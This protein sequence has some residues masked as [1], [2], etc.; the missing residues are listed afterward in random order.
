MGATPMLNQSIYAQMKKE[1]EKEKYTIAV[2][3]IS[4]ICINV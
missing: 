4:R 3:M 2:V 1:K